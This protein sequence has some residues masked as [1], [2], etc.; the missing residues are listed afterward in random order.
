MNKKIKKILLFI[1]LLIFVNSLYIVIPW[2]LLEAIRE[3]GMR[4]S[5]AADFLGFSY[6]TPALFLSQS[7]LLYLYFFRKF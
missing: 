4:N 5:F 3:L 6:L 1:F 2:V 7:I